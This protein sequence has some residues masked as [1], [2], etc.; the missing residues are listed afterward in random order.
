MLK[1][2]W[3]YA[4]QYWT[5]ILA[6]IVCSA[7]EAVFELLI[8]LVMSDIVDVGIASGNQSYILKKGVLMVLMAIV[9]LSFGLGRASAPI[10]AL[11]SMTTSRNL[12]SPTSRNFPRR[13]W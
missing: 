13:L 11:R 8:P 10:S 2:L 7:A 12:P 1:K 9:S 4:K 5:W 3:P 6:G